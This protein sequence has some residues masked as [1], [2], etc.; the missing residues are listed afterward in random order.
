MASFLARA[1][2]PVAAVL[3]VGAA[4]AQV[5]PPVG[6]DEFAQRRSS[7]WAWQPLRADAPPAAGHPPNT[8]GHRRC[9]KYYCTG[10]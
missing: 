1:L 2:W 5:P 6:A 9:A 8:R 10:H 3:L 7:H 4:R